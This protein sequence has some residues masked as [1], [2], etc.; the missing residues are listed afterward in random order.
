[1]ERFP[2]TLV[3]SLRGERHLLAVNLCS[4]ASANSAISAVNLFLGS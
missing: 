2:L 4:S 3:L 1:M